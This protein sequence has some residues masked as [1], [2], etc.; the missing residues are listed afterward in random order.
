MSKKIIGIENMDAEEINNELELGS[1]FVIFEYCISLIFFTMEIN[2]NIY[3]V[4][5]NDNSVTRSLKYSIVSFLFGWWGIP[6]GPFST[7]RSIY[8]NFRG[9][10]DITDEVIASITQNIVEYTLENE[11]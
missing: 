5:P 6:Y 2:T 11:Q 3:F 4:K 10:E 8:K 1:K 7:V 9:G